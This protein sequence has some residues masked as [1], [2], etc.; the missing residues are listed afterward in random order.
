VTGVPARSP[1]A[2]GLVPSDAQRTAIEAPLG[3]VLV[4]AGPGAGK[5]YCLIERV[6]HLITRMGIAPRRICAV[7]FTNRAA[8][9]IAT[10]LSDALGPAA[11]L[12][13]RGT[14][15]AL[16]AEVLRADGG[17]VGVPRGFGIADEPYQ[18]LL[19][20]RLGARRQ[21]V[22][23]L[24]TLFSRRRLQGRPLAVADEDLFRRYLA[25]LRRRDL[26]DF[27]DLIDQTVRLFRRH[28]E[29]EAGIAARWDYLLVDEFQDLDPGQYALIKGLA[30]GHRNVFVVGDDE[31]SIFS[32]RGA[33]PRVL[34]TFAEDFGITEPIVLDRNRR[35]SR[36]IFARA[37]ALIQVERGL[38][39]KRLEADRDSPHEVVAYRFAD[40]QEETAWLLDDLAADRRAAGLDW[41]DYALLYR[42]HEVGNRLE[43]ALLR[44]G[45]PCRLA[46]G[47]ALQDDPVV[48]YVVAALR[49]MRHPEDPVLVERFA[50]VLLPLDL[51]EQVRSGTPE[52]AADFLDGLRR[53]ARARP[54]GAPA[55][56]KAWRFIYLVENLAAEY[57]KNESLPALVESLLGQRVG[58]YSNALEDRYDELTDPADDPAAVELAARLA[59]ILHG[60]GRAVVAARGPVRIALKALLLD[61][62]VTL[63]AYEG[64]GG[65]T[66]ADA[67]PVDCGP[68]LLFKALQLVH[69]RALEHEFTDYVAFDLETT[70]HNV[71]ACEIVEIGAVRVRGGRVVDRFHALVRPR[72]AVSAAAR[73][74]HGY[75]DE[76][77]ADAP[78]FEAVWPAFRAFVGADLLV[79]HNAL[80]FDFPVLRRLA[81]PLGG[82]R[83]VTV[84]D[85]LLLAR[86]LFRTGARLATLAERFGIPPGRAHH[87]LDDAETL[88]AVIGELGRLQLARARKAALVNV[89]DHLGLGLAL[90][91]GPGGDEAEVFRELCRPYALG[92][93]SRCLEF[94]AAESRRLADL[95]L[96]TLDEVI[97]RLGG[98]TLM[99]RL[100]ADRT[101]ADRYPDAY[102]R[103]RRL[104]DG[105]PAGALA[106]SVDRLLD[107]VA[108]SASDGV[109]VDRHRVNLLTLHSTKGL[110]FS[111][112]YLIG[113]EDHELPGFYQT[114]ENRIDEI[115][116]A[117]RLMYVGMTRARDRLV[118]TRVERRNGREA[119]GNRFLDEMGVEPKAEGRRPKAE[120]AP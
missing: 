81:A 58:P 67:V 102:N 98:A 86:S 12:V 15:H 42:R 16:C 39:D 99:A 95:S 23:Q 62:D 111:R 90:S 28:P 101:A 17:P 73:E 60:R 33:D 76:D 87:A 83:D 92:R 2:P 25:E 112:V 113:A 75:G 21:R 97:E 74:V 47:R 114:T 57:R 85:S 19:L 96:P 44:A 52:G 3:P 71:D 93:Y 34:R 32:W 38:F 77:L 8:E 41:G 61:G 56:R 20:R 105:A 65:E 78:P 107:Q 69:S 49:V 91:D 36:Q 108:L 109:D 37:R 53:Y 68:L 4:V 29:I 50:E 79:A 117:R 118:L 26:L 106:E 110:E 72:G 22:G 9:E 31:Q 10:R 11:E 59:P 94:F 64:D 54:R 43:T 51:V 6:R 30:A 35:C 103:L 13:T 66:A 7:T 14:L 18:R 84:Y 120:L 45:I 5:T 46:R 27:D 115:E 1:E 119:G 82:I 48:S 40:D 100:R 24:L 88:A 63:A 116:E 104:L 80:E 70:D 89:L 55:A